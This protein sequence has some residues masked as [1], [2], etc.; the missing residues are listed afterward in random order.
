MTKK[1]RVVYQFK[2]YGYVATMVFIEVRLKLGNRSERLDFIAQVIAKCD[3]MVTRYLNLGRALTLYSL[4]LDEL[5]K[6][7]PYAHN[8][9]VCDGRHFYFFQ[10][11]RGLDE[12]AY[13]QFSLGRFPDG[14]RRISVERAAAL[15]DSISDCRAQVK[16]ICSICDGLYFVFLKACQS[17]LG[18]YWN[19]SVEKESTPGW[20]TAKIMAGKALEEATS[21]WDQYDKTEREESKKYAETALGF[22]NQRYESRCVSSLVAVYIHLG[23]EWF[24]PAALKPLSKNRRLFQVSRK[25]WRMNEAI[26]YARRSKH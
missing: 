12:N 16:Q 5:L 23:N 15:L 8:W 20:Q 25:I 3:G 22:L 24:P 1:D 6:W 18:A 17:G 14:A 26:C 7:I 2:T 4:F 9:V 13:P 19:R 11:V 21:A 10:F